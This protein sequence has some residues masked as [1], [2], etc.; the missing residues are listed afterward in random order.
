MKQIV[1]IN[2]LYIKIHE[3][4]IYNIDIDVVNR[5]YLDKKIKRINSL[6]Q[7]WH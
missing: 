5:R 1:S 2:I 4:N 7:N 6:K 3:R